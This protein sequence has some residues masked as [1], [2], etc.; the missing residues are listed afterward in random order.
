M[1]REVYNNFH[2]LSSGNI[3]LI[4]RRINVDATSRRCIHVEV[5]LH[6]CHL[7]AGINP[8]LDHISCLL[9]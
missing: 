1:M 2:H 8:S 9:F 5:T 4:Q 3:M 6:K 7:L